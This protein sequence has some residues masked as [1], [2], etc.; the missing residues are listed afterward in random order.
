MNP[1]Q[2]IRAVTFDVGGTL[3]EPWPGV[4][5]VYAE[6]ARSQGS[7]RVD[8]ELLEAR[9]KSVWRGQHRFD[10]SRAS[11]ARIVDEVFFGLVAVAPSQSFFPQIYDR[12]AQPDAWRIF[13]D[14]ASTL[15]Q[16]EAEGIRL[17]VI[18]NWD[19]RLRGLLERL[20][21]A[22]RF[23]VIT[24]SCEAGA[25]KPSA[26][27][28]Q[29]ALAAFGLPAENILHVGDSLE[30]DL[31]GAEASGMKAVRV[32][33]QTEQSQKGDCSSLTDVVRI[34]REGFD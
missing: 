16:L 7:G 20:G 19:G 23:E 30:M 33:R 18:S 34:V 14:V 5:R 17:G 15:D 1:S 3:I 21:L 9:F 6:T 32:K 13:Q 29:Q 27:I 31:C 24:I 25:A 26:R 28:F 10:Y 12:F 11:W 2:R 4:G 22:R 8:P